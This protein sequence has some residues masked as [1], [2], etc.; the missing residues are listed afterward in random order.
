MCVALDDPDCAISRFRGKP[1]DHE[2]AKTEL[3][4]AD[5][6]RNATCDHMLGA[7][8]SVE[9]FSEDAVPDDGPDVRVHGASLEEYVSQMRKPSIWAHE[10][11]L[12][13]VAKVVK[14]TLVVWTVAGGHVHSVQTSCFCFLIIFFFFL[15]TQDPAG[16][17]Y[18]GGDR[19]FC[20]GQGRR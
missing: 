12:P 6:L 2:V 7:D 18:T 15:P 8:V 1:A 4:A 10:Q 9:F 17:P 11:V 14:R 16:G 5:N 19:I 13:H 20:H 3:E